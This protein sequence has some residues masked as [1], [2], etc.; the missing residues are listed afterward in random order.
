MSPLCYLCSKQ[1]WCSQLS[2]IPRS[3]YLLL[4][5]F[6]CSSGKQC[7]IIWRNWILVPEYKNYKCILPILFT[8]LFFIGWWGNPQWWYSGLILDSLLRDNYWKTLGGALGIEPKLFTCKANT[9]Q[10]ILWF[11]PYCCCFFSNWNINKQFLSVTKSA[12]TLDITTIGMT[13]K[14]AAATI[15]TNRRTEG[16]ITLV[17]ANE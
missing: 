6:M 4:T 8:A 1:V 7:L 3:T 15:T 12:W 9:L 2:P 17:I 14:T 5:C 11:Q 10:A 16:Q 13:T